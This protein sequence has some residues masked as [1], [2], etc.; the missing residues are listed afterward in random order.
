ME[1]IEWS[2]DF[3]V[4]IELFDDHHKMLVKMLNSLVDINS[5][6]SNENIS[7]ILTL[8]VNYT[9]FHFESEEEL[10]DQEGFPELLSHKQEHFDLLE[11]VSTICYTDA[12][13]GTKTIEEIYLF[14][15]GWVSHHILKCDMKYKN[16]FNDRGIK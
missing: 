12:V 11:Q 9:E 7:G 6:T 1:K 14:L 10:M 2:D 8:I 15:K 3:S 13:Y 16:F 4:G 5:N